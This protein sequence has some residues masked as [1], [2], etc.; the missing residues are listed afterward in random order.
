MITPE[1]KLKRIIELD[2]IR[3]VACLLVICHHYFTGIIDHE[4]PIYIS[5]LIKILS[6]FFLSGVDLF[7][8]L[9]GFLV[10]GIIIDN[11]RKTNF[12]KVFFIRRVCRI[13]PVYFLL[14]FSFGFGLYF[15][16][17]SEILNHWLINKPH[18]L[19]TYLTFTQSYFMG[20]ENFSGAKWV[21]VSWSVSVEEQFYL[22]VPFIFILA[23]A[24]RSLKILL[25]GLII[26]PFL[27]HYFNSE[28]GFYAG[29]MFF[30][31]RMD[32]IFWGVLLAFVFRS[33]KWRELLI[34]YSFF[35]F[36]VLI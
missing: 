3:G 4:L 31:G 13:F 21:A 28:F 35:L 22:I 34:K 18:S 30:P 27:R 33:M 10:G 17:D 11:Y 6:I 9:S 15:F 14:I 36:L 23:G 2:G 16:G 8:V 25:L 19:W 20:I 12:L 29:Y 5:G 7:F 24:K 32:T 1:N 26:A